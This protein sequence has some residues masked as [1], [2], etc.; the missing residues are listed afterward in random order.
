LYLPGR[1]PDAIRRL[2]V[3]VDTSGSIGAAELARFGA[4]ID[5]LL[6][7]GAVSAV[8]VIYADA[9]VQGVVEFDAGD[10][11]KL[12]SKGGGGTDFAPAL[13]WIGEH[14]PDAIAC[15]YLTD[16][17][18]PAGPEPDFPVIWIDSHHGH[19]PAPPFGARVIMD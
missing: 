12:E 7:D 3:A 1:A 6:A 18:G 5:G 4:A 8:T 19:A 16:L 11:V 15:V 10:T 2:A 14:M 17:Y 13:A 9:E